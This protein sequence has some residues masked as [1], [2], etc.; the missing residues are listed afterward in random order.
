MSKGQS[1]PLTKGHFN[2]A[3]RWDSGPFSTSVCVAG[4]ELALCRTNQGRLLGEGP[5][6][7]VPE[8]A[9]WGSPPVLVTP[10]WP[11]HNRQEGQGWGGRDGCTSSWQRGF[12]L[13][14][15]DMKL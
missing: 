4:P 6:S 9:L 2:P 15:G 12:I 7:L 10:D 5:A 11:Q 13:N 14:N 1:W 8:V 3:G